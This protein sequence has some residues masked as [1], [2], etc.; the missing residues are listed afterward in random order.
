MPPIAYIIF[1]NIL[2]M[3]LKV[4]YCKETWKSNSLIANGTKNLQQSPKKR[5]NY[6][7]IALTAL[8]MQQKYGDKYCKA[9]II[10]TKRERYYLNREYFTFLKSQ[11]FFPQI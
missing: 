10:C 8:V 5:S 6:A 11:C 1:M 9:A 7:K 4:K 3:N 2:K